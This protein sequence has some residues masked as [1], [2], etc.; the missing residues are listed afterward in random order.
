MS[1]FLDFISDS[2]KRRTRK[3]VILAE[4][5]D[6][7]IVIVSLTR[8]SH[9]QIALILKAVLQ[10]RTEAFNVLHVRRHDIAKA[11]RGKFVLVKPNPLEIRVTCPVPIRP[12]A[13]T[14]GLKDGA[15]YANFEEGRS[16]LQSAC[17]VLAASV[18]A[19]L[20]SPQSSTG[21][22]GTE[23]LE[24]AVRRHQNDSHAISIQAPSAPADPLTPTPQDDRATFCNGLSDR[25]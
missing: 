1:E 9:P 21:Q 25:R 22:S 10:S 5:K 8:Y 19:A 20:G 17:Q 15:P 13:S 6:L 12:S 3:A 24:A 14:R 7:Y 4:K 11:T 18:A 2:A 16:W 23:L